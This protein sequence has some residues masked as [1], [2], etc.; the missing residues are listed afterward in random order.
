VW[1][2]QC[3]LSALMLLAQGPTKPPATSTRLLEAIDRRSRTFSVLSVSLGRFLDGVFRIE[4]FQQQAADRLCEC[5]S[6]ALAARTM[7]M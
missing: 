1:L 3:L 6:D 2:V 5:D 7:H 4:R